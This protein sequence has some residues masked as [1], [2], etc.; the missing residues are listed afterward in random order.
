MFLRY[1]LLVYEEHLQINNNYNNEACAK[2]IN[3]NKGHIWCYYLANHFTTEQ[4]KPLI[5]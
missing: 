5:K 4:R 1:V 3:S 2:I